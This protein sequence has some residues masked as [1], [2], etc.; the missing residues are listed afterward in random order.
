MSTVLETPQPEP[1]RSDKEW[2]AEAELVLSAL[3]VGAPTHDN[4]RRHP[5]RRYHVI[6]DLHLFTDGPGT[7]PWR[8]YTR[9]V[10][11]RGLGFITRDRLPLGY[12]GV[13]ELPGPTDRLMRVNVTLFRCREIGNGWFEGALYFN[14]EQWLFAPQ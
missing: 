2:L 7:P 6:A 3:E 13:V 11:A 1:L 12:G 4:R 10:S 14:R 9:D 5:R 8:L